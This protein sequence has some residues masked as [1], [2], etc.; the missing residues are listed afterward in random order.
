MNLKIANVVKYA[1]GNAP[2]AG[3]PIASERLFCCVGICEPHLKFGQ[4]ESFTTKTARSSLFAIIVP[5]GG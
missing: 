2:F 1:Q 5:S 3:I 4:C